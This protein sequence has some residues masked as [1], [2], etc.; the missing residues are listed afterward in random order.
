[1]ESIDKISNNCSLIS[2]NVLHS[3]A[4][5]EYAGEITKRLF[6]FIEEMSILFFIYL[7]TGGR[8]L[9]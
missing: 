6:L 7:L 3:K 2:G 4:I 5:N 1:M 8:S 9:R